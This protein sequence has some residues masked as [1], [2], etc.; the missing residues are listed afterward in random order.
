MSRLDP[1]NLTVLIAEIRNSRKYRDTGIPDATI[2]DILRQ[3]LARHPKPSEALRSARSIL[4]NVMAPYLGD[5]DPNQVRDMMDA[6]FASEDEGN[7][8]QA[9]RTILES[10]DSTRERLPYLE[11]FYRC[12][13]EACPQMRTILD[14]A[15]GLNPFAFPWMG[16]PSNVNFHAYD[17]HH[18]R[19]ELINQFLSGT[20]MQP[21]AEV[22]DILV[23]PHGIQADATFLFKEAH[24]MEKRRKGA[25]R[26]LIHALQA[27]VIF[28]SLPNRS[29]D[30]QRDLGVRMSRLVQSI[31]DGIGGE[32]FSQEFPGETLYWV[33]RTIG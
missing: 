25:S 28:I 11:D 16:L 31:F 33:E 14:L 10:H 12:I 24:R 2:E 6:A 18:P 30:G 32:I 29:L 21:L 15:C 13:R 7:I 4:H 26:A 8:R 1:E 20:G 9:A 23:D 3:E 19:V 22:R 27:R 17:I 5:L